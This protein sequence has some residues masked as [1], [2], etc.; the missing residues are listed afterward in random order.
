[1]K[2]ITSFILS[3]VLALCTV[4]P[5][6]I[7]A[8]TPEG[9]SEDYYDNLVGYWNFEGENALTNKATAAV[10][11]DNISVVDTED[12]DDI[13]T[14]LD[15][16]KIVV[17]A[18]AGNLLEVKAPKGS[19]LDTS[20]KMT[21]GFK[22]CISEFQA[23]NKS[24]T[25][26]IYRGNCYGI[27]TAHNA[28][29]YKLQYC[30]ETKTEE[31]CRQEMCAG[32]RFEYGKEYYI[33]ITVNRHIDGKCKIVSYWAEVTE[34][35]TLSFTSAIKS[36]TITSASIAGSG[37]DED[38]IF[39]SM[40]KKIYIGKSGEKAG[41]AVGT[42][43]LDELWIFDTVLDANT[44]AN[45]GSGKIDNTTTTISEVPTY[46]GCQVSAINAGRF[47]TRFVATIDSLDYYEV[48]F[49]IQITDYNGKSGEE[50]TYQTKTVYNSI[51]GNYE[52]KTLTYS[53][54]ELGGKYIY[55]LAVNNIIT[56]TAFTFKITPY[57]ILSEGEEA[58]LCTPYLVTVN[59]GAVV[60]QTVEE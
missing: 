20:K 59:N 19:P 38:G 12:A 4:A 1:M 25:W 23:E 2:K 43:S 15:A 35:K 18:D 37:L 8:S 49:K 22:I 40:D 9:E 46:R 30:A 11:G 60:S 48:G 34:N 36:P 44:I 56:N 52:N 13:T 41:G 58:K 24:A 47:S 54:T 17:P 6:S 28:D 45:I 39:V 53:A 7:Y 29:G 51:L 16:G 50:K 31:G 32:K 57:Y 5:M 14:K 10:I 3:I 33:F 27:R 26:L 55:A 21:L 42:I